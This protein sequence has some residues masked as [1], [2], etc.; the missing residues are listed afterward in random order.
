VSLMLAGSQLGITLCSLG[1][2]AIAEPAIGH[3]IERPLHLIGLPAQVGGPIAFVLALAVVVILH[4]VFGEV[5]PKNIALAGPDRVALLLCPPLVLVVRTL[6]PV[7]VALNAIANISL[8]VARV[9]PKDEVASAFTPDEVAGL[10]DQSHQEGLLDD[11]EHDL[12][13]GALGLANRDV[14]AVLVPPDRVVAMPID[15]TPDAVEQVAART[16]FSRFPVRGNDGRFVGYLHLKDVLAPDS[17]RRHRPVEAK[18]LRSLAHVGSHDT[19]RAVLV[20]MKDSGAHLAQVIA[21]GGASLGV[22]F[23][24]DVVEDLVGEIRDSNRRAA[25]S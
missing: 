8:R 16:G 22:I 19:L 20:R 24:E 11:D 13:A 18:R 6:R 1:L 7:V 14:R 25:A 3:L 17:A 9:I 10:I 4:V 5:V 23:L 2:G 12:L 15:S 21:P